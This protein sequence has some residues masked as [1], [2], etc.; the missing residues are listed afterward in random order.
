[1]N[2]LRPMFL[3]AAAFAIANAQAPVQGPDGGTGPFLPNI[4]VTGSVQFAA[5]VEGAP[6]P[7]DLRILV[8][9]H[10]NFTDG[11]VVSQG[12]RFRFVLTPGA[13]AIQAASI[14]SVEAKAF[15]Y[16]STIGHIPVQSSSGLFTLDPLTIQ[17]SDRGAV[18]KERTAKTVSATSLKAPPDAVKLLERGVQSLQKQK[19]AVAAKAFESAIKIYPDYAEAWLNLGRAR[20]SLGSMGPGRDAFI[21]AAE[22]DPQMAEPPAE[23]GLLAARQGDVASAARYLD[24][25]LRLDPAGTFQTCYSDALVNFVLRRYD[26]AERSARAALR[27]GE[28][29]AQAR[30]DYVLGMALLALGS[31]GEARQ[32]LVR[33]LE[34]APKAPERDQVMKELSRL[35]QIAAGNH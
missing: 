35:D 10:G 16:E 27:F 5:P 19:F 33:Y 13:L 8:D 34:L 2:A 9:C 31:N 6:L 29:P 4:V 3:S 20:V 28:T 21:R 24:E 11:G 26:V 30:A 7:S 15:G 23:L 17:R 25:S 12:G 32:R 14:C 1:M 18:P 22:L